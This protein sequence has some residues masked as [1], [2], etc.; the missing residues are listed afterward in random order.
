[1]NLSE[2]INL[3]SSLPIKS[4]NRG[5]FLYAEGDQPNHVYY[6]V[7]GIV[8][9]SYNTENGKNTFLR[10]FKEGDLIG[11]RSFFAEETH[12][13]TALAL[14]EIKVKIISH[15]ACEKICSD[16]PDI[17]KSIL[18]SLAKDL[19]SAEIRLATVQDKSVIKR[20]AEALLFL[21]IKDPLMAWK[22]K[23]IA[24]FASTTPESVARVISKLES[25]KIIEKN[26]RSI[27][28]LD[29]EKLKDFTN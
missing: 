7:D 27:N 13:A 26:G 17:L 9:L 20:V 4:L 15:Q 18:K 24:D 28:I 19:A 1:L 2:I 8:G 12:H 10:I 14:T 21:K 23:E 22:G 16:Q 11:H 6:L 29:E 25:S 3:D 5:E